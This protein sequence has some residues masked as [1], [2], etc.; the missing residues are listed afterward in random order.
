VLNKKQAVN[1]SKTQQT[2]FAESKFH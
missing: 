1:H 2:K